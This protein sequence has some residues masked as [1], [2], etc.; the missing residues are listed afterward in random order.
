MYTALSVLSAVVLSLIGLVSGW[1]KAVDR[2]RPGPFHKKITRTGWGLMSAVLACA[3]LNVSL[4]LSE[5]SVAQD[6]AE[7]SEGQLQALREKTTNNFIAD[8]EVRRWCEAAEA[9]TRAAHLRL[10]AE[11]CRVKA[12]LPGLGVARDAVADRGQP[13]AALPEDL[14]RYPRE[15]SVRLQN[16]YAVVRN[17]EMD[18]AAAFKLVGLE[19]PALPQI[20]DQVFEAMDRT[21][22]VAVGAARPAS[23]LGLDP[24]IARAAVEALETQLDF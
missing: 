5:Q 11:L 15:L 22:A 7:R 6:R 21:P 12:T 19:P 4:T 13:F 16:A 10:K 1:L 8:A 9:A 23:E 20:R 14:R 24:E 3:A 18:Y 2:D 17:A